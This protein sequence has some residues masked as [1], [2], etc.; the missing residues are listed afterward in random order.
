MLAGG[1]LAVVVICHNDPVLPPPLVVLGRLRDAGIF[2]GE[3]VADAVD[4]FV[5]CI[6]RSDQ[7]VVRNV[8]QVTAVTEPRACWCYVIR[9]ALALD[10]YQDWKIDK[11]LPIPWGEWSEA[12]DALRVWSYQD[13][14][15][16]AV[17][18]RC[19]ENVVCLGITVLGK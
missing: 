12:L 6:D 19:G 2:V 8:L 5:F 14:Y 7:G 18:R 3:D 1:A 11:V 9:R 13:F 10:L 17:R 16:V 15:I 4:L